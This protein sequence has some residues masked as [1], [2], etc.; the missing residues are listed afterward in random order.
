MTDELLMTPEY[1]R[2][3]A[4]SIRELAQRLS[5]PEA[6]DVL[7]EVAENFEHMAEIANRHRDKA[8]ASEAPPPD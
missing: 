4:T 6:R 1:W 5:D 7:E 2:S 8:E 3:R